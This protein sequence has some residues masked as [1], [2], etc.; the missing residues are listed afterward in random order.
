MAENKE[1]I[2]AKEDENKN[3]MNVE[4]EVEKLK[5]EIKRLGKIQEDGSYKVNQ[6]SITPFFCQFQDFLCS[7]LDRNLKIQSLY[8]II[9]Y[10]I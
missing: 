7:S 9:V 6:I 8:N 10:S 4:E 1:T 5:V 3:T 2:A